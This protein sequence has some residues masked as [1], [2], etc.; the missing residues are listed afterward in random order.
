MLSDFYDLSLFSNKLRLD[1]SIYYIYNVYMK[2]EWDPK[3]YKSN[4]Q[5]HLVSFDEAK[6]VFYDEEALLIPDP[7]HSIDED[8]FLLLGM[9][10]RI[11]ELVVS[12]CERNYENGIEVIRIISARKADPEERTEYWRMKRK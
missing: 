6:S 5:K 9:S 8:R 10:E 12:Y 2:F 11:R 1:R 3:K 4:Q 7:S